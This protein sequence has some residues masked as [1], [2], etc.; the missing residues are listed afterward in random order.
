MFNGPI[1]SYHP[2]RAFSG[3][4]L[5]AMS[6]TYTNLWHAVLCQVGSCVGSDGTCYPTDGST[7]A[8][9]SL[10]V[11]T[12]CPPA[13]TLCSVSTNG[14]ADVLI[15]SNCNGVG[16]CSTT[17]GTAGNDHYKSALIS[18]LHCFNLFVVRQWPYCLRVVLKR[19]LVMCPF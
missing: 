6:Q 10:V 12:P 9:A 18:I 17:A 8:P 4:T 7:C 14:G 16:Q 19:L 13:T 3:P 11:N 5:Y 1:D 15:N 2:C